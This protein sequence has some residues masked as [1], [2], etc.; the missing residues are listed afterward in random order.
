MSLS[1]FSRRKGHQLTK[2]VLKCDCM[3]FLG[4]NM[5]QLFLPHMLIHSK[6]CKLHD[7]KSEFVKYGDKKLPFEQSQMV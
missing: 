6:L 3:S 7:S 5:V 4:V 2:I 1:V